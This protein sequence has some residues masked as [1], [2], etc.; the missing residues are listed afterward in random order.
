MA[1]DIFISSHNAISNRF[2]IF[3]D[4]EKIAFMY[5][6]ESGSQKPVKDAIAYSRIPPIAKVDWD[7]IKQYG[8]APLLEQSMASSDAV[9]AN[10]LEKDCSFRW[11]KDGHAVAILR[12]GKPI[13]FTSATER[14]GFSK[15]VSKLSHLAN[16]WDQKKYESFFC[17]N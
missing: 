1:K 6:T 7:R 17:K 13:A 3:E 14:F 8:D 2:A 5:L 4:N 11:S 12:N 10:P 15:A 9:I 16:V